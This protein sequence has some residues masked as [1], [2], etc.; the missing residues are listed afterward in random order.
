MV[1][2]RMHDIYNT[3]KH[4]S[5]IIIETITKHHQPMKTSHKSIIFMIIASTL[6][7]FFSASCGT[8]NGVGKDVDTVGDS[9]QHA[10]RGR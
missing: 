5:S 10:S 6:W 9:I 4:S 2:S 7:A 1:A 8:V 3:W